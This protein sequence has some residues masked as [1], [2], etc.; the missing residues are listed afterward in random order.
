MSDNY[1]IPL[2]CAPQ[3]NCSVPSFEFVGL[4]IGDGCWKRKPREQAGIKNLRTVLS[5][6]FWA[7]SAQRQKLGK[8]Q[9]SYV[10]YS[11]QIMQILLIQRQK[12]WDSRGERTV[13]WNKKIKIK[14]LQLHQRVIVSWV[15]APFSF[16]AKTDAVI[17]VLSHWTRSDA[18]LLI[19]RL[20]VWL[21][22]EESQNCSKV[23][24]EEHPW[25]WQGCIAAISSW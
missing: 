20:L 4:F 19:V 15:I 25:Q 22:L 23:R 13:S 3:E 5:P 14:Y 24:L 21:C 12:L 16:V 2:N 6:T 1:V 18:Q 17:T 7:H 8:V 10:V 9:N 11:Y